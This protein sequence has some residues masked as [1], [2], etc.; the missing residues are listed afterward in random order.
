[1]NK[2]IQKHALKQKLRRLDR[3]SARIRRLEKELSYLRGEKKRLGHEIFAL[4]E[5]QED[6]R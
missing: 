1:M 5:K 4:L 3:C 6:G 2:A